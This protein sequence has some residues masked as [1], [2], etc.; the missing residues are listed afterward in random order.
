[1]AQ[2]KEFSEMVRQGLA[3]NL[4]KARALHYP[5]LEVIDHI[6]A[7]GNPAGVK[8]C[9]QIKGI[10][11]EHVRLPLVPISRERYRKLED[12]LRSY[13]ETDLENLKRLLK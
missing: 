5:Q 13:Q 12:L 2:P 3:G 4:E 1:M 10:C 11:E 6:F 8:A 7:E 9:L